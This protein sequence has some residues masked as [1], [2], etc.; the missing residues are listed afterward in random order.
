MP[1]GKVAAA[2]IAYSDISQAIRVLMVSYV[3]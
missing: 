2:M 3:E 1:L